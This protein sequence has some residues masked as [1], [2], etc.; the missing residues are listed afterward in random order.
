MFSPGTSV[1]LA[2]SWEPGRG[3]T[4]TEGVQLGGSGGKKKKGQGQGHPISII[5]EKE[6]E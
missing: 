5:F 6:T 3:T 2:K 1:K 4:L